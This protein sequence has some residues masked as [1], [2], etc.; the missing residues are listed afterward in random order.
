MAKILADPVNALERSLAALREKRSQL[1][2]RHKSATQAAVVAHDQRREALLNGAPADKA[3]KLVVETA[4]SKLGLEDALA[5]LD[6][7]IGD[8]ERSLAE[9]REM[10]K[11]TEEAS[12]KRSLADEIERGH[13]T[14]LAA[15]QP[16]IA[17]LDSCSPQSMGPRLAEILK[18]AAR[19]FEMALPSTLAELRH[20]AALL[21]D[22]SVTAKALRHHGIWPM[23]PGVSPPSPKGDGRAF[24]RHMDAGV[25]I[26]HSHFPLTAPDVGRPPSAKER[27]QEIAAAADK[28]PATIGKPYKATVSVDRK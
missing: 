16:L 17:T 13:Q 24:L 14:F 7:Q 1:T 22:Q 2:A 10:R 19:E 9:A 25:D 27:D 26:P 20:H 12:R 23:L 3:D 5:S 28:F 8:V 11:R 4:A 18:I 6:Q 15:A 21:S